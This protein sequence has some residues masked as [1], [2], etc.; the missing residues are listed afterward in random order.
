MTTVIWAIT[1]ETLDLLVYIASG[2]KSLRE[3]VQ[4]QPGRRQQ[5]QVPRQLAR[6]EARGLVQCEETSSGVRWRA[7]QHGA[8][9]VAFLSEAVVRERLA[10]ESERRE[11]AARVCR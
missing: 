11:G 2:P 8:H 3:I 4:R 9:C 5:V 1:A 10:R 6:L 7:T